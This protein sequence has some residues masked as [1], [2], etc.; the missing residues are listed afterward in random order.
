[1]KK[2]ELVK[3]AKEINTIIE[4]PIDVSS[5]LTNWKPNCLRLL[6]L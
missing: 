5:V 2:S 6:R 4:P 3:A 1:M